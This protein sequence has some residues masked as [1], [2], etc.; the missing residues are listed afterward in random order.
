M[1]VCKSRTTQMKDKLFST[2]SPHQGSEPPLCRLLNL[3][4]MDC[5]RVF[6]SGRHPEWEIRKKKKKN[7]SW[8]FMMDV[9][10]HN[11]SWDRTLTDRMQIINLYEMSWLVGTH[12]ETRRGFLPGWNP[13]LTRKRLKLL[14]CSERLV[15]IVKL[16][17]VCSILLEL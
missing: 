7:P 11:Q 14:L 15:S 10:P 5:Y 1:W 8:A 13:K 6:L 4:M 16:L 17:P 9:S 2:L 12:R 3:S